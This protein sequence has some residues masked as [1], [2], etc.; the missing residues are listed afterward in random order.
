MNVPEINVLSR[1][2]PITVYDK[3]SINVQ[4]PPWHFNSFMDSFFAMDTFYITFILIRA[5]EIINAVHICINYGHILNH[6]VE[7]DWSCV[8]THDIDY[9]E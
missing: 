8:S 7:F 2:F 6:A 5:I 1:I 4:N 9:V 3:I